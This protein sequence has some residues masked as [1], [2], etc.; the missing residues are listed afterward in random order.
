MQI[1]YSPVF[2]GTSLFVP[3]NL[4]AW[5]EETILALSVPL[6]LGFLVCVLL[7]CPS[8]TVHLVLHY[9]A[10]DVTQCQAIVIFR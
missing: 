6:K 5:L 2:F 4:I 8:I 10:I 9:V 3:D 7:L 1:L